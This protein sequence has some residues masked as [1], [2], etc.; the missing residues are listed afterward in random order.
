MADSGVHMTM[1]QSS[2]A[3]DVCDVQGLKFCRFTG[4]GR[5]TICSCGQALDYR[6]SA[7]NKVSR[8]EERMN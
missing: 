3:D 8:T 5:E 1:E 2:M 4:A 7:V 6:R